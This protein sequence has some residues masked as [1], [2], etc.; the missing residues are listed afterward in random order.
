MGDA[1]TDGYQTSL[2]YPAELV[3]L[4]DPGA[5]RPGCVLRVRALVEGQPVANR[6]VVSGGRTPSG[7]RIARLSIRTDSAG[8]APASGSARAARGT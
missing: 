5:L 3:P 1:R 8:G 6:L 4:D 2:G 7:G